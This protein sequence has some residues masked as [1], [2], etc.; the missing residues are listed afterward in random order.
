MTERPILPDTS[1]WVDYLRD[2]IDGHAGELDRLLEERRVL[3]CGPVAAEVLAGAR[4]AEADQLGRAL[5]ALPWAPLDQAAWIAVGAAAATLRERGERVPLTDIEIA[6]S[7][8][9]A[10]A[11]LWSRDSDFERIARALPGLRVVAEA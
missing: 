4:G 9:R 3:T 10:E 2:G 6:V 11:V 8:H 1:V 7:A 5:R